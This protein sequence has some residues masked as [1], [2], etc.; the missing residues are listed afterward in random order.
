M[1]SGCILPI[2]LQPQSSF[3]Q[4]LEDKTEKQL[5]IV[6]PLMDC[7]AKHDL[8]KHTIVLQINKDLNFYNLQKGMTNSSK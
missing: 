4:Q 8:D 1:T 5:K 6:S 3:V 2:S 7:I